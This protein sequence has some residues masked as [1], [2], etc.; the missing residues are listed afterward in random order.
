MSEQVDTPKEKIYYDQRSVAFSRST[1]PVV[2][3][4]LELQ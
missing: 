2:E 3:C 4:L 1:T